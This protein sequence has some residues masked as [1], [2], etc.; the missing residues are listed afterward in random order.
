MSRIISGKLRL[1][2]QPVELPAVIQRGRGDRAAGG[3]RQGHPVRDDR[4]SPRRPVSGDPER[5]RQILWNLLSN[6]VK[7]TE[8][9]GRVQ[10]RLERVNSHVEITVSDTGDRHS[11]RV[12]SARVRALPAGGCRHQPRARRPRPRPGDRPSPG[13]A[14]GRPDFRGQRRAGEGVDVPDRAAGQERARRP[15][16][17]GARTSAAPPRRGQHCRAAAPR[18]FGSWRSTTTATRSRSSGRFSKRPG[19]PSRPPI[20]ASTR[21][22]NGTDAAR[23]AARRPGHAAHERIRAHRSCPSVRASPRSERSL[24]PR[25]R[26]SRDPKIARRRCAA[27]SDAPGEADRS[28]RAD[29]GDGRAGGTQGR[30]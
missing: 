12:S 15:A 24:P 6:A 29:G 23:R 20:R 10:V 3:R 30:A 26:R 9:G 17:R 4:R 1:D 28:G 14:P 8:R 7:F 19:P 5:L 2:V 25:S 11:E 22:S 18:R 13:R 27:A 21:S 16:A